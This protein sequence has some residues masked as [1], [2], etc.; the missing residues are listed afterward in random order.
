MTPGRANFGGAAA[1]DRRFV[2]ALARG[3][4]VLRAFRPGDGMLGNQEI[5]ARTGLPKPTVSRLT[6]T[7]TTLGYL[8]RLERFGKYQIAPAA[9]ALGYSAL[10]QGGLRHV[11]R[12]HMQALAD[13]AVAAV[14]LGARDQRR[15]IYVEQC[16]SAQALMVRLDVGSRIPIASSAMGRAMI[17]ALPDGERAALMA[18]LE[19]RYGEDWPALYAAIEQGRAD[20]ARHGFVLSIGDWRADIN[21]VGVPLVMADGSGIYAFNCGAAAF[22]IGRDRLVEDIGPRLVHAVRNIAAVVNGGGLESEIGV[23]RYE[24]WVGGARER[25]HQSGGRRRG[26]RHPG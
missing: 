4:D 3:L 12:P 19:R 1:L 18:E 2:V 15:M 24:P 13:H 23:S 11:A 10:A 8:V 26:D 5:A 6:Y 22:A 17:A 16:V 25:G 14:A 7:L 20:Y 21:G 9:L